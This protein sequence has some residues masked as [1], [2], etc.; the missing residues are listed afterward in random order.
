MDKQTNEYVLGENVATPHPSRKMKKEM[1][2][3]QVNLASRIVLL[4]FKG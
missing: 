2:T 3:F 1:Q 4:P